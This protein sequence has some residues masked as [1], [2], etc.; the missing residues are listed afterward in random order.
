M[1]YLVA[2]LGNI[3]DE[4]ASTRHNMG[5]MVVDAWAQA[6]NTVFTVGRYG[7]TAEVSFKGRKFVLLKPSTYM[8]LSGKA[9]NYYLQ[10]LK[11]PRENLMVVVDD[12]AL[13]FGTIRM[14]KRGSAGGHNGLKS[15]DYCLASDDYARLRIGIGS[16]FREGGQ[17]DYVLGELLLEEK[18]ALPE[19]LER[20][21][22]AIKCFGTEGIDRAMTRYNHSSSP[23]SESSTKK[24][25]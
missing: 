10:T 15:I 4:Y 7:S 22:S 3:G 21:V 19:L 20:A 8:N 5:F 23:S 2:G 12:L 11:I 25:E 18:R 13:P 6:S 24:E 9:V 14:R 17:I 1:T 16:G